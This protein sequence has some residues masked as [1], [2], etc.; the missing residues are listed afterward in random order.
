MRLLRAGQRSAR[1]LNCGVRSH[2]MAR[3]SRPWIWFLTVEAVA[4]VLGEI[5][6]LFES[7][8]GPG[9]WF[10]SFF[11]LQP[12]LNLVGPVVEH[13]LWGTGVSLAQI[14]I[15]ESMASVAVNAIL[16]SA[17]LWVRKKARSSGAI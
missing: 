11:L 3:L 13:L 5:A 4:V 15:W 8:L 9:M 7:A 12:G 14:S 2:Y 1:R 16:F 10:A 6:G 17:I